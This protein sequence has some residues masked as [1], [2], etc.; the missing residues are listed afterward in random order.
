MNRPVG[1]SPKELSAEEIAMAEAALALFT[2]EHWDKPVPVL[3]E[4]TRTAV[5]GLFKQRNMNVRFGSW[6]INPEGQPTLSIVLG[7]NPEG[8]TILHEEPKAVVG[9][10]FWGEE[11]HSEGVSVWI[12]NVESSEPETVI[13]DRS[14]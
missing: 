14:V 2:E 6:P 12:P 1:E 11:Y 7:G 8:K 5:M 3:D 4:A 9:P 13:F 10:Y